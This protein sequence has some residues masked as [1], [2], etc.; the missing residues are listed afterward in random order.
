MD[1][2]KFNQIL[3]HI[4]NG[5]SLKSACADVKRNKRDFYKYM[6]DNQERMNLYA[7]AC[8]E[9]SENKVSEMH[10]IIDTEP[11]VQ[12]A[13]LKIDVIKWE[14]SKLKPKKYGDFSH[15]EVGGTIK[16]IIEFKQ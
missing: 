7:C 4:E 6:K 12:K 2:E 16:H 9:R 10:E 14:A 11:D 1:E 5:F 8:E 15:N 13:R 3:E